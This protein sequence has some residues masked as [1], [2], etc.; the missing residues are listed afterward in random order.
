MSDKTKIEWSDATWNMLYGCARVSPGCENCYA[1][2]HCH[3][4]SGEGQRHEG[5]TVLGGTGPRWT[6]KIQLAP[7]RLD[8][9]LRWKRPRMIFTNSLSDLFHKDVPFA[10]IAQVFGVMAAAPQHTFQVLTKRAD[11]MVEFFEWLHS[12][13]PGS[14]GHGCAFFALG[15]GHKSIKQLA[16]PG[17]KI[18]WPLP[19]V[20]LGVSAENQKYADERISLLMRCP[21]AVHWVSAEPLLGPIDFIKTS[22]HWGPAG[23]RVMKMP[24]WPGLG[25]VVVGGESGPGSRRMDPKWARSIRDQCEELRVPWLFKQL[26][27]VW[28]KDVPG[29]DKKGGN[30]EVWPQEFRVREYPRAA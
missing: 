27:S 7:E 23:E 30:W 24:R 5:L 6:G 13:F 16:A 8:V 14:P 20:W 12:E 4:F 17:V 9:P 2:K 1:E 25:W 11:R 19:N 22:K 15:V 28:A 10:F 18:P 3:R 26:G 29:S 21:A